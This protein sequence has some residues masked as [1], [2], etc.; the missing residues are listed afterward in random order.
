V[1]SEQERGIHT[2]IAPATTYRPEK[3]SFSSALAV[4]NLPSASTMSAE[5]R[6]SICLGR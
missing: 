4:K 1:Q 6:L 3:S 2:K 5:S